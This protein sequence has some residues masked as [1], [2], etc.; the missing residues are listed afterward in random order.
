MKWISRR[1]LI[2]GMKLRRISPFGNPLS[3]EMRS[4]S[5]GLWFDEAWVME[6]EKLMDGMDNW[7]T[8]AGA[9]MGGIKSTPIPIVIIQLLLTSQG[10]RSR[11]VVYSSRKVKVANN[12]DAGC[13]DDG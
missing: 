4:T 6:L 7:S 5:N 8:M 2:G 13:E 1:G 12:H 3:N 9:N 11:P 10:I